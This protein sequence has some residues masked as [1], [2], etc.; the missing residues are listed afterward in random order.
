MTGLVLA[1]VANLAGI[2]GLVTT[3]LHYCYVKQWQSRIDHPNEYPRVAVIAPNRGPIIQE[4]VDALVTQEYPG[5]WEIIFVTTR[6]DTSYHQL[7]HY[8]KD[9][10]HVRVELAD[11]VVQ[12]A[13]ERDVHRGQKAHN[14][15]TALSTVSPETAIIAVIDND[16]YPSH[17]WL[18]TLIEP[19]S[20]ADAKLGATTF[21]RLYIPGPGL[22]SCTQ[23]VW[24]LGSDAF[25][26]G[27]WGY[28]WGGSFAIRKEILEQTD[29]L[30]RWK[31]LQGSISSDDLNLSVALRRGRYRRCY[32]PG[33]KAIRRPPHERETWSDVLRFTNRQILHTWWA[34]KDLWLAAFLSHGV[35][36]LAVLS[37]LCIAWLQPVALFGLIAPVMDT[38]GFLLTVY[39]LRSLDSPDL[40]LHRSLRKAVLLAGPLAPILG[41]IN[42]ITAMVKT[43]MRWGGVEYTRTAV[44][45]YTRDDS[46]RAVR[47]DKDV[48][49]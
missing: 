48:D 6:E 28:V 39:T 33:F 31:G 3:W 12:L 19:F 24:V 5:E 13:K 16:V 2:A 46:W 44:L 41:A 32:V 30:D 49:G 17:D 1:M 47:S 20:G 4:C 10:A 14:L 21:A 8:A 15:V 40:Q 23:A 38:V 35:K 45:G 18:Q 42:L 9:N 34:R 7:Q 22:A 36:S 11:D 26:V 29:A 37:S 25:L 27:P 43:R